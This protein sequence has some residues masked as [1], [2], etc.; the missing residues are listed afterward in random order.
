MRDVLIVGNDDSVPLLINSLH[1]LNWQAVH[2][3]TCEH[4]I[5]ALSRDRFHV[6]LILLNDRTINC[7]PELT[8]MM[9]SDSEMEWIATLHSSNLSSATCCRFI[10]E[11]CFDYHT[12]PLDEKRLSNSLG[13]AYGKALLKHRVTHHKKNI[14]GTLL[15]QSEAMQSLYRE[16]LK[17]S[18]VNSPVLLC[19]ESGTGKELVANLIHKNSARS[20]KPF[21]TVNCGAIPTNLIQSELFG[22]E[23][24]A[25]TGAWEKKKGKIE[26]AQSGTIFLDEIGDLPLSLQTNL[27]RFLQEKT[28]ERVGSS[29]SLSIDARVIAAT[30]IDLE[31]A[32]KNG[33]F[34]ED[35]YY[36][37]NVLN[38]NLPPLRER[39][40]D[41]ELLATAFLE[42]FSHKNRRVQG[43]TQKALRQMNNYSWPGNVR[44]LINRIQRAV[45][46]SENHLIS[47]QDLGLEKG[48]IPHKNQT[49][50]QVRYLADRT[51]VRNSLR[52]NG[53]NISATARQLGISR[54]TLYRLIEKLQINVANTQ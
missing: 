51:A 25:F 15:G 33:N 2:A 35:V 18:R 7:L 46:M 40:G 37:L 3:V 26:T 19:G 11:N 12:F 36:R 13:H 9:R 5:N 47:P 43:F 1:K 27:L 30:N 50:D 20:G 16:I 45:V 10:T 39:T 44:E 52:N 41:I 6:G 8:N 28:I 54:V 14:S 31:K 49:L 32:V 38:I 4:T 42:K 22:H 21:V 29:R 34:R 23:K 53:N 24:G 48:D 17:I